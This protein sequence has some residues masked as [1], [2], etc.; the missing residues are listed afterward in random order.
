MRSRESKTISAKGNHV[1]WLFFS[2]R[3]EG[4]QEEGED[5]DESH[6]DLLFKD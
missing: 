4:N 1:P 5:E 2:E 6:G 3:V